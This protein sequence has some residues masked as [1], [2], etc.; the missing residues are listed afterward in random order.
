M[1][2]RFA[3]VVLLA[4]GL[5]ACSDPPAKVAG[6]TAAD[7]DAD[8]ASGAGDVVKLEL[9]GNDTAI[10][11]G[12]CP[13]SPGCSCVSAEECGTGVCADSGETATGKACAYPFGS[14]C[15]A[16][17]VAFTATVGEGASVCV[18]A[19]PKLC[20]PC[21]K[22]SDCAS[23]GSSGAL[24]IDRGAEG[25]FCGV[26]CPDGTCPTAYACLDATSGGGAQAKQCRPVDA[27]GAKTA[28]GCS[29][30]AA[31]L[32]LATPC[33]VVTAAGACS[34]Q[35][36]CGAAGLG[37]CAGKIA[38]A[39]TCDGADNDCN[40]KTDDGAVCD[41][42]SLCT[43]GD[44]CA[45][46]KCGAGVAVVCNDKNDCTDDSCDPKTGKCL[47]ANKPD[48]SGCDDSDTCSAGEACAGGL[49]QGGK[50]VCLCKADS[51]CASSDDGKACT[52][53]YYCDKSA[54]VWACKLNPASVVVCAPSL[55]PCQK[56][57][58]VEPA[59]TCAAVS[60]PDGQTCD[61]GK[62]WTVGDSCQAGQCAPGLNTK[63]TSDSECAKN[64]DGDLC[65]GTLF[66]NKATG[67]CQLNPKT[68]VLCPTVDDTVCRKS[69]CQPKSAVCLLT[70]IDAQKPC[71]DGNLCT[72]GEACVQGVCTATP[73]GDTCLCKQDADCGKFEDGDA[74]NGTLF[75]N[76]AKTKC[77]LN[78]KTIVQCPSAQD[79][80]CA[81]NQ[82]DKKTGQCALVPTVGNV[83]CDADA[84]DCTPVDLCKSGACVA[85]TANVCQCQQDVDCKDDGDLC[86]GL[87]YC[88]K[89][90]NLC[91]TNPATVV[92]CATGDDTPC[93][94]TVCAA[95]T[96]LCAKLPVTG[97]CSDGDACTINDVCASGTC[98]GGAYTCGGC[99]ADAECPDDSNAC[100]GSEV[101]DKEQSPPK[102]AVKS[103]PA[104]GAVC[105]DGDACTT[106][107][108]CGGGKCAGK[109]L[110]CNDQEACTDDA[111][112]GGSCVFLAN[113]A[114]CTDGDVCTV[115]DFCL[116][117]N[118]KSGK[119]LS[120]DDSSVC[121]ADSCDFAK[122]C[123]HAAVVA[124]C[125]DGNACTIGDTCTAGKCGGTAKPCADTNVCTDDGCDPGSGCTN[126]PNTVTC[127]DGNA[128]TEGD[129]CAA[130]LC[131]PGAGKP[132]CG[133]TGCPPTGSGGSC[134]GGK[135]T[136][137]SGHCFWT[138]T[139][140]YKWTLVP[141]GKFWMGCN[142]A[143][144]SSCT[145]TGNETPQHEVDLSA[146]WIGVYEVTATQYKAC[147]TAAFAGCTVPSATTGDYATYATGGKE[148][149]PINYVNWA[150]SQAVCKYLG[151]DL[152]TE[153]QWE[154]AARGGCEVYAGKDCKT[155][156]TL[157]PWGSAAPVCGGNA[158]M[159]YTGTC[160]A[161]M[162]VGA[163]SASGQ[164]P[165]GAFDMAG[166]VYEWVQDWYAVGF[167]GT[168][169]ATVKDPVNATSASDRVLRGGSLYSDASGV[170]AGFRLNGTPSNSNDLIGAR[171]F[172][173]V[174]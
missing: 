31:A 87:P 73:S 112:Q 86:N 150:E 38:E 104:S 49:C 83:A 78:P 59:G 108:A 109:A 93:I 146:Y 110:V 98:K 144:D 130:G 56:S 76:L 80:P 147:V 113:T 140:G 8:A 102:C 20:N 28:C 18:P 34:G 155:S 70:P 117:K 122:G 139:T 33:Q 133:G 60:L 62:A 26:A 111:C 151:G 153:A 84:S 19:A 64:E 118:C 165:Y 68:V 9:G 94:Q 6:P 10:V 40:G 22:D 163:G 106:G 103:V 115:G 99:V 162:A 32:K 47:F 158:V 11:G 67:V 168:A 85:D 71:E 5:S 12:A 44:D 92:K 149:H 43:V 156:E 74:C 101:C 53:G 75:C 50:S 128:C 96:G 15:A 88:N 24:C 134:G 145:G 16:G 2:Y 27:A 35:R 51:D 41:D 82:C 138:D 131:K 52:G 58:C 172:R 21:D 159:G 17:Q 125:N 124:G 29:A 152:P 171:C 69:M 36:A 55:N 161:L 173:S 81:S 25:R 164:S 30:A 95:A 105:S 23:L 42:G 97:P 114:T 129:A 119:A 116:W 120:C 174:P 3:F 137:D 77:E 13:G 45:G 170:R 100:N 48:G 136:C 1:Y 157:Y 14:G 79:G 141:A 39:E 57:Q 166:N 65:N 135:G 132:N 121:T 127:T 154:K 4:L 66:C 63:C 54:P 46:G 89:A 169:P 72:T 90:Q 123:A 107:D 143:L 167:Y 142:P 7:A 61:D 91:V 160:T 148:K 37:G 126:L